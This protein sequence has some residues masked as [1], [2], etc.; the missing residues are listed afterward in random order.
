MEDLIN[1]YH[2]VT[3]VEASCSMNKEQRDQYYELNKVYKSLS[4]SRMNFSVCRKKNLIS[5]VEL[6]LAQNGYTSN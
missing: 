4:K 2:A 5:K 3:S 6:Y 1:L